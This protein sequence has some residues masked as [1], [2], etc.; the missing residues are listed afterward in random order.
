MNGIGVVARSE[1]TRQFEDCFALRAR[2]DTTPN[3]TAF[4]MTTCLRMTLRSLTTVLC[5]VTLFFSALPLHA[6]NAAPVKLEIL[7]APDSGKNIYQ[8]NV[9]FPNGKMD[10]GKFNL[11]YYVGDLPGPIFNQIDLPF[12]FQM[13]LNGVYAGT[14]QIK[15]ALENE[16]DQIIESNAVTVVT[17]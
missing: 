14:Y 7:E 2:N 17:K 6:Q 9:S 13:N 12:S 5:A 8:V 16:S 1:A 4:K 11:M 10:A 15:V 3:F